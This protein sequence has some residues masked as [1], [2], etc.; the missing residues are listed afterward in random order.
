MKRIATLIVAAG[1]AS[2][3]HAGVSAIDPFFGDHF[4]TFE[5]IGPPGSV[6]GQVPIFDG[7][8][9]I[10]D[11]LANQ[12]I[13]AISLTSFLTDETIFSYNGNFM[14]GL[15]TGWAVIEFDQGATDFG[16]YFGT[17]DI[18]NGGNISF[19]NDED[20]LIETV[21]MDIPLNDWTWFGFHSDEAFSKVVIHGSASPAS[22]I[23]LDDLQ[24]NFIPAPSALALIGLGGL[25][26]TRRRR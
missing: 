25:V 3:A 19:F 14:G 26:G 21:S 2:H 15:P 22:P 24:V 17:A 18:L 9:T 4:E 20:E 10:T 16:G 1:L 5:L 7:H 13:A 11:E 12:V 23:V 6:F 8:A